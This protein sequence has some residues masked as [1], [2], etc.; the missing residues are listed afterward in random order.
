MSIKNFFYTMS[1]SSTKMLEVYIKNSSEA[2]KKNVFNMAF[3]KIS[4]IYNRY[5][6]DVEGKGKE[7]ITKQIKI[8]NYLVDI[9]TDKSKNSD[10]SHL[11]H[12]KSEHKL[13]MLAA[14][15]DYSNKKITAESMVKLLLGSTYN[16]NI[17]V[18]SAN[19]DFSGSDLSNTIVETSN[20]IPLLRA[21]FSE[22]NAENTK[23]NIPVKIDVDYNFTNTNL[24]NATIKLDIQYD[25][26]SD[27]VMSSLFGNDDFPYK[28]VF[29]SI[30]TIDNKYIGIKQEAF[31]KLA[32]AYAGRKDYF[33][34]NSLI[35]QSFLEQYRDINMALDGN[36]HDADYMA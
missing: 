16:R 10:S 26:L 18:S 20:N 31:N 21:N 2:N 28:S 1:N 12:V 6:W 14:Y 23:I 4:N 24:K 22:A 13:D 25:N 30:S 5:G 15:Y 36:K 32:K 27:T 9:N 29:S 35:K 34:K 19:I 17:H 33:E 11:L 3:S 7:K 8:L